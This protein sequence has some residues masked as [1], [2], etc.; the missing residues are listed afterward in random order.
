VHEKTERR[1]KVSALAREKVRSQLRSR[2]SQLSK[3]FRIADV[4]SIGHLDFQDFKECIHAAGILICDT[5]CRNLLVNALGGPVEHTS[6]NYSEFMDNIDREICDLTGQDRPIIES[7][8]RSRKS[9]ITEVKTPKADAADLNPDRDF[10]FRLMEHILIERE[11]DVK[12]ALSKN[13]APISLHEFKQSLKEIDIVL[14][15]SGAS[16]FYQKAVGPDGQFNFK[17]LCGGD[18][19]AHSGVLQ[20]PLSSSDAEA[21]YHRNKPATEVTSVLHKVARSRSFNPHKLASMFKKFN[22][23]SAFDRVSIPE[24]AQVLID[25]NIDITRPEATRCAMALSDNDGFVNCSAFVRDVEAAADP[26]GRHSAQEAQAAP[27]SAHARVLAS[28]P[29]FG[30]ALESSRDSWIEKV[31]KNSLKDVNRFEFARI[32]SISRPST[33]NIGPPKIL[34]LSCSPLSFETLQ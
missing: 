25:S 29:A 17:R 3:A 34:H 18:T 16:Y 22:P 23:E 30:S 8:M 14:D 32:Q 31:V 7:M 19:P 4:H 21:R 13:R 5:D 20:E 28:K 33:G 6:V 10:P 12:S 15:D 1:S 9:M 24:F 11:Q 2:K 26:G 27:V